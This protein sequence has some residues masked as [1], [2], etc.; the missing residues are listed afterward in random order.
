LKGRKGATRVFTAAPGGLPADHA[1]FLDAFRKGDFE[2]ADKLLATLQAASPPALLDL[3]RL[4]RAR[5]DAASAAQAA[6]WDGVYDPD[7]K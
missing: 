2:A 3:Y 4:Y 7:R 1:G 5:L 6:D